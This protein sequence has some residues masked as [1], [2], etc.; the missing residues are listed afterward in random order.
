M[1]LRSR[2]IPNH[3]PDDAPQP[4]ERPAQTT[5]RRRPSAT[6]QRASARHARE[7]A[8]D[9]A[10]AIVPLSQNGVRHAIRYADWLLETN[11]T[12]LHAHFVADGRRLY[13]LWQDCDV[14]TRSGANS[15]RV[16]QNDF[17]AFVRFVQNEAGV[18]ITDD[19][20]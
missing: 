7:R 4:T 3:R 19:V 20:K 14:A 1:K 6:A 18:D 16:R 17:E 10:D 13:R 2:T 11:N 12:S 9:D 5:A 8:D 15:K